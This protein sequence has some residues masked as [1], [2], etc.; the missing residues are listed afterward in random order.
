MSEI[1]NIKISDLISA[2]D[3]PF[4]V[5]LDTAMERLIESIAETG[6]IASIIVRSTKMVNTRLSADTAENTPAN[7][8]VWKLYRQS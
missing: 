5:T 2:P 7:I 1:K 6:I 3:N 4:K 8:W